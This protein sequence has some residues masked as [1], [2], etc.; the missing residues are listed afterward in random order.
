MKNYYTFILLFFSATFFSC[1]ETIEDGLW[2][3]IIKFDSKKAEFTA[4]GGSKLINSQGDWWWICHDISTKDSTIF[5][6]NNPDI[7]V[8]M[9]KI[10]GWD[11]PNVIYDEGAD[12][13][14]KKIEGG[15]F[16]ITKTSDKSLLIETK[17]NE[18]DTIRSLGLTIQAG[19]YFDYITV[20][21]S[22]D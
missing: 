8:E 12:M 2:G 20:S 11:N 1:E 22:A 18:T 19:N 21:Q 6:D 15:W 13:E 4:E 7:K 17:P 5:L 3:D 10:K 14:I 16:T 9:G